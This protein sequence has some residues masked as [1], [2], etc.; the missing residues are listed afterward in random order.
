MNSKLKQYLRNIIIGTTK[1]I[2][3]EDRSIFFMTSIQGPVLIDVTECCKAGPI[4][5]ENYCPNCG[6]RIVPDARK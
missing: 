2:E 3:V 5:N 4:S 6:K 1:V